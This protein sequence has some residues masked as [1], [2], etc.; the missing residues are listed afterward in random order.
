MRPG[1]VASRRVHSAGHFSDASSP[2]PLRRRTEPA[3]VPGVAGRPPFPIVDLSRHVQNSTVTRIKS[4]HIKGFRSLADVRV[5]DMPRATVMIGANGSGKSNVIKFFAMLSWMLKS[6]KLG[7]F[8][9]L[10]GGAGDQLFG[11][12]KTTKHLE[13]SI[14]IQADNGID[15]Y[16]FQLGYG[17][18]DRFVFLDERFRFT[19]DDLASEP[20]WAHLGSGHGEAKIREVREEEQAMEHGV[21]YQTAR[22]IMKLLCNI[23]PY[24]FHDTSYDSWFMKTWD[25][26]DDSQLRSHGGNLAAVLY[27]L[28]H[29]EPGRY[30]TICEHIRRI[31]PVFDGFALE[32][33]HGKVILRWKHTQNEQIVGAHVTSDGSL[34]FFALATLLNL[35]PDMLPGVLLLDEPELGLHPMAVELVGGMIKSLAVERQVLVA[36]QSPLLVNAFEVD[37]VFVFD[38]KE[39]QTKVTR[40]TQT[41][42]DDWLAEYSLGQLWQKNLLG[43]RP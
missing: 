19:R 23:A 7:D 10:N 22:V 31:L 32:E 9:Q 6:G 40:H 17:H 5:T 26:T 4:F 8:V 33:R 27:R 13:A 18:P 43:G 30:R 1:V 14:T 2:C 12:S 37:E 41:D 21:K 36:T 16:S 3:I 34:R 42:Y 39:G 35:P 25:T 15:E 28:E 24:Q 38:L 20:N 29:D 11:G